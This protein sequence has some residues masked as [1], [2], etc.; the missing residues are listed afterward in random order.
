MKGIRKKIIG[1]FLAAVMC[2]SIIPSAAF[3]EDAPVAD[4]AETVSA[5]GEEMPDGAEKTEE[6][7][8]SDASA[9]IGGDLGNI[10]ISKGDLKEL[11]SAFGVPHHKHSEDIV[12]FPETPDLPEG[13]ED[14][15]DGEVLDEI[16]G[17]PEDAMS[18]AEYQQIQTLSLD[19]PVVQAADKEIPESEL[20]GPL[21]VI[22]VN[23]E[24]YRGGDLTVQESDNFSYIVGWSPNLKSGHMT[25]SDGSWFETELFQVPGLNLTKSSTVPLM[26]NG[27]K[28]GTYSLNYNQ[29]TGKMMYKVVFNQYIQF[30]DPSTILAY[31]QG[32]GKFIIPMN[33]GTIAQGGDSG[34]L[35]VTPRPSVP[36]VPVIP[37]GTGWQPSK[38]PVFN[39]SSVYGF[40]KGIKWN[41]SGD[42]NG[43]PQM[44]WRVVF[45]E[46]LQKT[47]QEFLKGETLSE[48]NGYLIFTDT[49][50]ENQNF[51][52]ASVK[53]NYVNNAPFFL[54]LPVIVPG[55]GNIL[56]GTANVGNANYDGP[57]LI[58]SVITGA[59]FT[60]IDGSKATKAEEIQEIQQEVRNTP[61]SWTVTTDPSTRQQT[62]LVNTGVLGT[63]DS[64]KGITW[65]MA[66]NS[67]WANTVLQGKIKECD[68]KIEAL[69]TGQDSPIA[70][71][72]SRANTLNTLLERAVELPANAGQKEELAK[73]LKAWRDDFENR[74][75]FDNI[76][77]QKPLEDENG[78][79]L[80]PLPQMELIEA[81][82]DCVTDT[83]GTLL[84]NT[85]AYKNY[86]LSLTNLQADQKTYLAN[87]S[88]YGA[89]WEAAKENYQKTLNFYQDGRVYGFVVK[90]RTK[91][92]NTS[93]TSYENSAGIDLDKKK[94][95]ADDTAAVRFT[96]GIIGNFALGDFVL[97]KADAFFKTENEDVK[98]IQAVE[99]AN[100]GLAGAKFQ[101][102]CGLE[103]NKDGENLTDDYLAHF[104]DKDASKNG[105]TYRYTHTGNQPSGALAGNIS[106][107]EVD[108]KGKLILSNIIAHPHYLVE[109]EAPTGYYL[110]TTPIRVD[111]VD[112]E[113][114]YKLV[115]NI[116][117]SV[118]LYKKDSYSGNPV[119]GA[120]FALYRVENGTETAVTGFAKKSL[121][122]HQTYWKT[123]GGKEKLLTNEDGALCIHGLDAGEYVLREVKPAAG[124]LTPDTMP[125]FSFTLTEKLPTDIK[126]SGNYDADGHLLLTTA[127]KPLENDPDVAT[128]KLTK[129]SLTKTPL[130][131]A[132]FALFRFTGTEKQW[133]E[134]PDDSTLWKAVSLKDG[135]KYFQTNNTIQKATLAGDGQMETDTVDAILTGADGKLMLTDIPFGHYCISEV[136]APSTAY[137]RDYR[138]FYFNVT[139]DTVNT[140]VKLYTD[141]QENTPLN[142]NTDENI[143]ID[144]HRKAFLALV[145]YDTAE[146]KPEIN[147]N[148]IGDGWQYTKSILKTGKGL[149]GATYKLFMY[150]GDSTT[151]L[152]PDPEQ[153][154]TSTLQPNKAGAGYD[155]CFAVGTTNADGVLDVKEMKGINDTKLETGLNPGEYYMIEVAAPEGYLL[156]QTPIRF[157]LNESVF[158]KDESVDAGLVMAAGNDK[159][160]YGIRLKKVDAE[161]S[162]ALADAAFSVKEGDKELSF[163]KEEDG[164]YRKVTAGTANATV[165]TDKKGM[166]TLVGLDKD[167]TYTL[168]ETKAPQGYAVA[169]AVSVKTPADVADAALEG[170]VLFP[171]ELTQV[172][173]ERLT[174]EATL[175]KR[176][177]E[178]NISLQGAE[179]TLYRIETTKVP[180]TDP[181]YDPENP[182]R[183]ENVLGETKT[184][185]A[186]GNLTFGNL[187]WGNYYLQ[188]TKAPT[189]YQ[190]DETKR[191]FSIGA[192]SF[193]VGGKAIPVD[194]P[195]LTNTREVEVTLMKV[196]ARNSGT[197]LSGA[198][199]YLEKELQTEDGTEWISFGQGMYETDENGEIHVLL[200]PGNY[201][202]TEI[203]APSGYRLDS[204]P[205]P[206]RVT[207]D[208]TI[209]GNLQIENTGIKHS[210]GG[211]EENHKEISVSV[212]KVWKA[213]GKHPKSVYAQLYCSGEV[214]GRAV[215]LS[216]ENNWSYTWRGLS[217]Q[218]TWIVD[219]V[220]VPNGYEKQV[221]HEGNSWKITNI[222]RGTP[223]EQP[224]D[225][226]HPINP[227]EPTN[228]EQP[229]NPE[230]PT[231]PTN[232]SQ[233]SN[234]TNPSNPSNPTS[235]AQIN[236]TQPTE[237]TEKRTDAVPQTGDAFPLSFWQGALCL[238]LLGMGLL[239]RFFSR[240][241]DK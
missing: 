14:L 197:R 220:D 95:K 165:V 18:T 179:F 208:G 207:N 106:T 152:N 90:V 161:T 232:P 209:E 133:K 155:N 191:Y 137:Q 67:G 38:A 93:V 48:S 47:Q 225:P 160:D 52:V 222:E 129:T 203:K 88:T 80:A 171:K 230:N 98:D 148:K 188:E 195:S 85:A 46:Q 105:D 231:D 42:P 76:D 241:K 31:L 186:D 211:G 178:A 234:P 164:T 6:T 189:G 240:K 177:A 150:Q 21:V 51:H 66:S 16:Y 190:L 154:N 20:S 132:G 111:N 157:S 5:A 226:N 77:N 156:D 84:K 102:Y 35:T 237:E 63:T 64:S 17:Q 30:F 91:A 142:Q 13:P 172:A 127:D 34:T 135:R 144:Y 45:L 196:D 40:G 15:A 69:R 159:K 116:S 4:S 70:L 58:S 55:T 68:A 130:A 25:W 169:N 141:P 103:G 110:D 7:E 24:P 180:A 201:R 100:A 61:L 134:N 146:K 53:E 200:T 73:K 81:L 153:L 87:L 162:A 163:V 12:E 205:I 126:T 221:S 140:S 194:F 224:T 119:E 199:F 228:P 75:G 219:E 217:D 72:R 26:L 113:V 202:V 214:Y 79:L 59:S 174:G 28:V 36:D 44:E 235:S 149:A 2:I 124:Y 3:A 109:T 236:G 181:D 29:T 104:L 125:S 97:Q 123:A 82:Q 204:T 11:D 94:W 121:N 71:I 62:L 89:D 37:S 185:D 50:D 206:F 227:T 213:Q 92:I 182:V 39:N 168:K 131:N 193:D 115:P 210:S 136:Q 239:K 166:L 173:D 145:K 143:L 33:G 54:E 175:H 147:G 233:P 151:T 118:L 99:K 192:T 41:S 229:S 96:T 10:I 8:K 83:K 122:G 19:A 170:T 212:K 167:T 27:I 117:R 215:K 114:N 23:G 158:P 78:N 65:S 238:S 138:S 139:G 22:Y 112:T 198:E 216:A 184:T 49:L 43:T 187:V 128:L 60:E 108:A 1:I 183:T 74:R 218:D 223:S 9:D 107:L 56:N 32:S 120:E 86:V 57:G 176:A 101:V